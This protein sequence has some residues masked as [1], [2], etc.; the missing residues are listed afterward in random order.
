LPARDLGNSYQVCKKWKSIIQKNENDFWKALYKHRWQNADD[1]LL[2]YLKDWK[3]AYFD[4]FNHSYTQKVLNEKRKATVGVIETLALFFTMAVFFSFM[5]SMFYSRALGFA[6]AIIVSFFATLLCRWVLMYRFRTY[7]GRLSNYLFQWQYFLPMRYFLHS[8]PNNNE[9]QQVSKF[10][11]LMGLQIWMFFHLRVFVEIHWFFYLFIANYICYIFVDSYYIQPSTDR[12][13]N[14]EQWKNYY[15]RSR[16]GAIVA[17][18][19]FGML[20]KNSYWLVLCWSLFG[21]WLPFAWVIIPRVFVCG[22]LARPQPQHHFHWFIDR[23]ILV[24]SAISPIF[25]LSLFEATKMDGSWDEL[26][27]YSKKKIAII[28][29]LIGFASGVTF[30]NMDSTTTDFSILLSRL[31]ISLCAAFLG[32]WMAYWKIFF[33]EREKAEKE[34]GKIKTLK[35]SRNEE[36][37]EIEKED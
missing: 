36:T 7:D 15:I 33:K 12:F 3:T 26:Q 16:L 37:E 18:I 20:G 34:F 23:F 27:F 11:M 35:F 19:L 5:I 6:V 2:E 29:A 9:E 22:L 14:T 28:G 8:A 30:L 13:L 31:F 10:W 24:P 32:Q 4:S 17:A 21:A 25:I 1:E